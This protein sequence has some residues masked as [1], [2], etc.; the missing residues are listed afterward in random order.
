ML[1]AFL[2]CYNLQILYDL[3][4]INTVA[5]QQ[6]GDLKVINILLGLMSCSS[7]CGCCYCQARRN[8]DEWKFHSAGRERD[9]AK[10]VSYNVVETSLLFDDDD[11][12]STLVL[13]KCPPP[14]L[15]LKLSL[16]HILVELSK[17]WPPLVDWLKTKQ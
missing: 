16:N 8:S 9:K 3:T 14:A 7:V 15:H 5:Y 1:K 12:P 2:P 4:K 10:D 17:A 11:L 13:E 6:T